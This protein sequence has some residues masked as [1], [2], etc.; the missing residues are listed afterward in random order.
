M[1][2]WVQSIYFKSIPPAFVWDDSKIF[3]ILLSFQYT[4]PQKLFSSLFFLSQN[5]K[6]NKNN[7][8]NVAHG[9]IFNNHVKW[10]V[11]HM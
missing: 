1:G 3:L 6:K 7:D 11:V 8:A 5:L 2:I 10:P 9:P 4:K